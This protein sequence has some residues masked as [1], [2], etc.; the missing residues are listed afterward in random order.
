[1]LSKERYT[2]ELIFSKRK[3]RFIEC[4]INPTSHQVRFDTRSFYCG[5]PSMNRDWCVAIRK[6]LDVID[7]LLL[8]S[9]R[10]QVVKSAMH[11]WY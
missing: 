4:D 1:M 9:F 2:R 3:L 8:G 10:R 7:I 11:G 5:K 6:M